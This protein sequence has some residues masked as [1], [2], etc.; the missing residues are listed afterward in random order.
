V[1]TLLLNYTV[2]RSTVLSCS[3]SCDQN[4]EQLVKIA[5]KQH[6]FKGTTITLAQFTQPFFKKH[7]V[8]YNKTTNFLYHLHETVYISV[9]LH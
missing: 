2:I 9:T 5:N 1:F 4:N 6:S 7:N 8:L 3:I